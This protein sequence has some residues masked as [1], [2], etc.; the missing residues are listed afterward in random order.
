MNTYESGILLHSHARGKIVEQQASDPTLVDL[1]YPRFAVNEGIIIS[2]RISC[3][4]DLMPDNCNSCP[5]VNGFLIIPVYNSCLELV[6]IFIS[7][8]IHVI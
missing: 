6:K 4:D 3:L 7:L 2:A 1:D 8:K 5:K